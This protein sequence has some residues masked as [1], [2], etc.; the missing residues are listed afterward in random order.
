MRFFDF[1][2]AIVLV[3]TLA[4]YFLRSGGDVPPAY[5]IGAVLIAAVVV[6]IQFAWALTW[7][8]Q[9]VE[10]FSRLCQSGGWFVIAIT[11]AAFMLFENWSTD[12][13]VGIRRLPMTYAWWSLAIAA[14]GYFTWYGI[15]LK[16]FESRHR[17][18]PDFA[19][20]D[21]GNPQRST[22]GPE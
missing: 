10:R 8:R 9:S 12:R 1:L 11:A 5:C 21:E 17:V 13:S 16:N 7:K 19:E 15:S 2:G 4:L 20:D 14:A 22:G 6:A 18:D 3:P